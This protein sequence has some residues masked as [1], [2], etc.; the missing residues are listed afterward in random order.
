[1]HKLE[2]GQKII[3][4]LKL[5]NININ[6]FNEVCAHPGLCNMQKLKTPL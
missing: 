6:T 4:Y 1:M 5:N 3:N 2:I